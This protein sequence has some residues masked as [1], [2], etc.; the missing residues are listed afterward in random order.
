[1]KVPLEI[2]ATLAAVL[3]PAAAVA[4]AAAPQPTAAPKGAQPSA[5]ATSVRITLHPMPEP[6]PALKYQLLPPFL[7]RRPGNAAVWWNRL[8]ARRWL[9]NDLY[10]EAGPWDKIAKWMEMPVG[11]RREKECR[12]KEPKITLCLGAGSLYS[13][14]ARAARFESC[15]WELPLREGN[16]IMMLLPEVQELRT[17]GRLLGAKAHLEIAEGKYDEAVATLQDGFAL[18]RH[19]AQGQTLVHALVGSAIA[20]QMTKQVEQFIQQP[21]APNLYWALA[22][23]PRPIVDY[24]PGFEAESNF[25]YLQFP[26][27]RDLDKKD[28]SAGQWRELLDKVVRDVEQVGRFAGGSGQPRATTMT[29]AAQGYPRA[30]QYLIEH[31]RPAAQVEAMPLARVVLLYSVALYEELSDDYFKWTFLPDAE[32]KAGRDQSDRSLKDGCRREIIP[33]A[34]SL[35]PGSAAAREAETKTQW[36]LVP[37]RICEALRTYAAAHGG[38]LPDRLSDI[39]EVP[40]PL[41]PCD[42]K[43]F[44]YYRQGSRA[45]LE[46]EHGPVATPWRYEISMVPKAK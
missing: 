37:L 23:L 25:L 38:Q 12:A 14:M 45:V 41:N 27:L 10:K 4:Q 5:V 32:G 39:G 29:N 7:E 30:K 43:P 19:T 17:W 36:L 13:D 33:L 20:G 6:R 28:L 42:D 34:S 8:L 21:D 46:A 26:E 40:I 11:D 15:D 18:A 3:M 35:M 9:L 22:T 24:R 31:G 2:L 44:Q 16:F 1:M